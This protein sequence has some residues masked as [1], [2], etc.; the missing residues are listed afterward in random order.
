MT[1]V[2]WRTDPV[3][4]GLR[5]VGARTGLLA[6]VSFTSP[7]RAAEDAVIADAEPASLRRTLP[8]SVEREPPLGLGG[9]GE[10]VSEAA[11]TLL[12][13]FFERYCVFHPLGDAFDRTTES[14]RSLCERD[15]PTM[16]YRYLDVV[17][18]ERSAT[19]GFRAFDRDARVDWVRGLT[20]TGERPYVPA[21]LISLSHQV[22]RTLGDR[23]PHFYAS[24]NGTACGSEPAGAVLRSLSELLERDAIM[25]TWYAQRSPPV[26]DASEC[27]PVADALARAATPSVSH[28]LVDLGGVGDVH[29]VGAIVT[30]DDETAPAFVVAASAAID[31]V[32]AAREAIVEST[33]GYRHMR[34]LARTRGLAG[35][36]DLR[37][38]TNLWA[39]PQYYAR[40]EGLEHVRFL[41]EGPVESR[42]G[43]RSRPDSQRGELRELLARLRRADVSPIL[44]DVTTPDVRELGMHV[45]RAVAPSLVDM[46]LPALPP[47]DH[48]AFDGDLAT[49]KGHPIA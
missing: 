2:G 21:A 26:L 11:T 42:T 30:T 20:P 3:R 9:K 19:L 41:L 13:E 8:L 47:V 4:R 17:D 10:T 5:A 33:Q 15:C 31:F 27:S 7:P 32:T 44:F 24:S 29:V 48:P 35:D 23:R 46:P 14:Y 37:T 6:D 28:T 49:R 12:G 25:R 16:P 45:T 18:Q 34:K 38:Q 39:C 22:E 40:P 1:E 36:V 43:D